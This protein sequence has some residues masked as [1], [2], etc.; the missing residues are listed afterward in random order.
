M[1]SDRLAHSTPILASYMLL[2]LPR[3]GGGQQKRN[4]PGVTGMG[5]TPSPSLSVG[6]DM[7]ASISPTEPVDAA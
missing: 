6:A 7:T 2:A 1:R 3:A 5:S 4:K